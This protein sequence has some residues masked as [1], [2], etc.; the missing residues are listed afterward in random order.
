[1]SIGYSS[2]LLTSKTKV[3]PL[4]E[5]TIPRLE[6]LGAVILARLMTSV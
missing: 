4:K 5:Q 1:M 3:A 2:E 6:L